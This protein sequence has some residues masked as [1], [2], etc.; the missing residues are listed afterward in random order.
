MELTDWMIIL[1]VALMTIAFFC[2]RARANWSLENR[3]RRLTG[4][5]LLVQAALA[6]WSALLLLQRGVFALED[7]A[8]LRLAPHTV[9]AG[10]LMLIAV[11]CYWSVRGSRLLKPRRLFAAS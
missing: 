7:I 3:V 8:G 1:A 4:T 10:A 6:L 5:R 2:T 11:A 9:M